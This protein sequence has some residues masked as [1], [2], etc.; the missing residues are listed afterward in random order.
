M[1]VQQLWLKAIPDNRNDVQ[2][3]HNQFLHLKTPQC[4][5]LGDLLCTSG[6]GGS[7]VV[8][9]VVGLS[10]QVVNPVLPN[11]F[12]ISTALP[13]LWANDCSCYRL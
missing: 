8:A 12:L 11:S 3:P 1:H 9:G 7:L 5:P 13:I 6:V 4:C 2:C 10:G